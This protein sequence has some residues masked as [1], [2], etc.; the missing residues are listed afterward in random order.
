M[1]GVSRIIRSERIIRRGQNARSEQDYPE[2]QNA[3]RERIIR[4]G[5][6]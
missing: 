5:A 1:P 2:G 3:R 4:R 6:G